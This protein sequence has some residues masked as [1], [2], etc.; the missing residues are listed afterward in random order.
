[1]KSK[2]L[3]SER[4]KQ[5]Q[6]VESPIPKKKVQKKQSPPRNDEFMSPVAQKKLPSLQ[7][8]MS[9]SFTPINADK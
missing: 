1:M 9:A 7:G 2:P 8:V 4:D 3:K 6:M 5:K